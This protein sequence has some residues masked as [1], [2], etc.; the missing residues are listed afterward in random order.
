MGAKQGRRRRGREE[1]RA[2][3]TT[4]MGRPPSNLPPKRG[5]PSSSAASQKLSDV[6]QDVYN[7][8]RSKEG[9]GIFVGDLKRELKL[10]DAIVKKSLKVLESQKLIKGV[11]DVHH[12]L[13]KHYMAV[14]FE[15]SKEI[16]GGS[17]SGCFN[18]EVSS[19][20]ILEILQALVLDNEIEEVKSTGKGGFSSIPLGKMQCGIYEKNYA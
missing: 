5:R 14:E 8:V 11:N 19:H 16:T 1:T 20:Q 7:L 10:Q 17:W 2:D 13:N 6:E 12:K 4:D 18:D 3:A 9:M 15:A